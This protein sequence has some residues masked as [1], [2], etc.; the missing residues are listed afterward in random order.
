MKKLIP[1]APYLNLTLAYQKP[2]LN[3][4]GFFMVGI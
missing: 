4:L 3:P 1:H 2:Q